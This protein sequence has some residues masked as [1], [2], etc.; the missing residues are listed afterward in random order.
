FVNYNI[1]DQVELAGLGAPAEY[2]G[3]TGVGFNSTTKSGG[4]Q[5]TGLYHAYFTN[6]SLTWSNRAP[7]GLNPT[8]KKYLKPTANMGGP[9]IK[10][11]LWWYAS[12]QYFNEVQN[13]GGP[14]ITTKSPRGFGKIDWQINANNK[15]G[16]WLEYDYYDVLHRGGDAITPAEAT[17][18][19]SAPEWVW[20]VGWKSVLSSTTVFDMTF[21]GYWGYYYLDPEE[22]YNLA[23]HYD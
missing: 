15:F 20:N 19:E 18:H 6:Y 11:K 21:Q 23:G 7:E 10:D 4:D 16:A 12:A 1:I 14:D 9:F 2:G 5:L 3:V 8:Q 17:V 13:N 22:G